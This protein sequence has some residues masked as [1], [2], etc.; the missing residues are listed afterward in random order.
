V[1]NFLAALIF[2]YMSAF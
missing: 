2:Q 1:I